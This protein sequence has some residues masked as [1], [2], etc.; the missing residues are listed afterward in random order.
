MLAQIFSKAID[1]GAKDA[2]GVALPQREVSYLQRLRALFVIQHLHANSA[3]LQV[4]GHI[5]APQRQWLEHELSALCGELRPA[6][7][8][9]VDA[10]DFS[11]HFLNSALG[12]FDGVLSILCSDRKD[13]GRE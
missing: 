13:G 5:T 7:L 6:A 10:F 4:Q 12:R 9:L 2:E 8:A 1:G 11:D 3:H